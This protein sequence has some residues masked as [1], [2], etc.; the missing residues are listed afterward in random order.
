[1]ATSS[2]VRAGGAFV[3]LF[4][5]SSKLTQGLKLAEGK[6]QA[7]GASISSMGVKMAAFGG[8]ITTPLLAA[9]NAYVDNAAGLGKM[10]QR[11]GIAVE[12]LSA[13]GY[14]AQRSGLDVEG[15]EMGIR[16]MQ[17]TLFEGGEGS[18]KARRSLKDLGISLNDLK[19]LTPDQ[20]LLKLADAFKGIHDPT[21][22]AGLAMAVFGKQGTSM[23]P[24]L[25]RGSEGI[26]AMQEEARKLGIVL[27][28][29]D[30][31]TAKEFRSAMAQINA[32]IMAVKIAVGQAVIPAMT[33]LRER[34]MPVVSQAIAW[35]RANKMLFDVLFDVATGI[36]VVGLSIKGL[37]IAVSI[38]GGMLVPAWKAL[39][40][41]VISLASPLGIITTAILGLGAAFLYMTE[42]GGRVRE[43]FSGLFA[44][45]GA[46]F[47]ETWKGIMDA[48][49]GNQLGLAF[50]IAL[51]GMKVA[52]LELKLFMTSVWQEALIT[53]KFA[54][55]KFW[56]DLQRVQSAFSGYIAAGLVGLGRVVGLISAEDM[57]A[58]LE[59]IKRQTT[60]EQVALNA[61]GN[62]GRPGISPEDQRALAAQ[63][64]E[65]AKAQADLAAL[66]G[67]AAEAALGQ[68]KG[69]MD[70]L[71]IPGKLGGGGTG[72]GTFSASGAMALGAGGNWQQQLIDSDK[73]KEE[74]LNK[75]I[76]VLRD[77]GVRFA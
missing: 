49:K 27:G 11:T 55:L 3:E 39:G 25:E 31:K 20:Q 74:L 72:V 5:D 67:K 38:V 54:W 14:A 61:P 52:W 13:L 73:R 23:I 47:G 28:V 63:K 6:L 42:S 69:G 45:I 2:D 46:T 1:M 18:D 7:W 58:M 75:I 60:A 22:K 35:I 62:A 17:K 15:L 65:L 57:K 9:A 44:E 77:A 56:V 32:S 48:L 33:R 24:F 34:I 68:V 29:D 59:D 30:V 76:D 21:Q 43:A 36:T 41:V 71:P 66:T 53:M 26:K 64:A 16:K 12:E 51:A 19:G 50:D 70:A 40:F 8:L 10:S 4:A 37:G